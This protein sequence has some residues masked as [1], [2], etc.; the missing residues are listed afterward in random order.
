MGACALKKVLG[1]NSLV[2]KYGGANGSSCW[3]FLFF[4]CASEYLCIKEAFLKVFI[5][6]M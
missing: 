1:S 6:T 4:C 5:I 3:G 2:Y